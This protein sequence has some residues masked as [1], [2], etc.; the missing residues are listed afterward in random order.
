M[1]SK[2][3][4]KKHKGIMKDM[5]DKSRSSNLYLPGYPEREKAE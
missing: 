4:K 1:Q 3:R 2:M 5:E